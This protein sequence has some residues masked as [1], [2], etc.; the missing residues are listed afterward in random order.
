MKKGFSL[1]YKILILLTIIPAISLSVYG[2]LAMSTFSNDKIA[3]VFES[4]GNL[5]MAL[6]QQM[7]MAI[8]SEVTKNRHY[9]QSYL[10]NGNFDQVKSIFFESSDNTRAIIA[11]SIDKRNFGIKN[12]TILKKNDF[13][14]ED[15]E[16]VVD[17]T[18]NYEIQKNSDN[19]R[20]LY[21]VKRDENLY[22][23][24]KIFN[25]NDKVPA[26]AFAIVFKLEDLYETFKSSANQN[27]FLI[28]QFGQILLSNKSVS[29][30]YLNEIYKAQFLSNKDS[31]FTQGVEEVQDIKNRDYFLSFA[32]VGFGE[33]FV[34][35][36]VDKA[37]ALSARDQLLIKSVFFLMIL[38]GVISILSLVASGTVTETLTRLFEA[39][40]QVSKGKFD[41]KVDV[42]STDEIGSLANNFNLMAKEVSRLMAETAE[43]ARM[44]NELQTAKTVQETLFPM[45]KAT[46][47]SI[48]VTGYYEPASECGGD[49]W[50]YCE[51]DDK[52][53][54]WIGDATGHGAPSALIT[55]A[56]RSAAV[57][58]ESL[59]VG[60]AEAME[61]LNKCIYEVSRGKLM[62]TF[63]IAAYDQTNRKLVYAN[64]SHESPFFIKAKND[65]IK[66]KDLVPLND[67]VNP[68]LGQSKD[69][70]YEEF[71]IDFEAGDFLLFYTDGVP[72]VRSAEGD[73]WGER[74]FIKTI[75]ESYNK[76]P[77]TDL[78]IERFVQKM[79]T[80]RKST[81]L[82][83]DVTLFAIR[84]I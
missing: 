55:S 46:M 77:E 65:P 84:G 58:I 30:S 36:A 74:E 31:H 69:T 25:E 44:Q 15:F 72:D 61:Y 18:V 47:G 62:M 75:I 76:G 39:T 10:S 9:L 14:I 38:I 2:F 81:D 52:V 53:F 41:I 59:K 40:E 22:F 68:R 67:V 3:Y 50:H 20:I 13:K 80:Y 26:F 27:L 49:W 83:D 48:S 5:S 37:V 6:A 4:S 82:V 35:S 54:F 21:T 64:A 33:S 57:I 43:S 51:I 73:A 16:S 71:E 17:R 23:F 34:I 12:K 28:N 42:Q 78:F 70:K 45:P 56:A 8:Q 60:P 29:Q 66:K 7:K 19:S 79:Q 24:E 63:F 11:Y 1:K 32:D